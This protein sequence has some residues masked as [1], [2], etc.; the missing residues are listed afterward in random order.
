MSVIVDKLCEFC[1]INL[2]KNKKNRFCSNS[3]SAKGSGTKRANSL[4]QNHLKK[5]GVTNPSQRNDVKEKIKKR[6]RRV[7]V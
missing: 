2:V 7:C 5:Y 1:N 3:C 6:P 4:K